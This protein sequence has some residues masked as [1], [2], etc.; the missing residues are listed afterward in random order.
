LNLKVVADKFYLNSSYLS[1]VFK[2]GTGISFSEYLIKIRMEKAISM[3]K[4]QDYKAYQLAQIVGI[5]DP[6]YFVKCFK[7]VVG[8]PFAE[9]KLK[10]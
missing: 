2:K 10:K 6:N 9:Y 7:K 3:L 5:P 1:R 8:I 4:I